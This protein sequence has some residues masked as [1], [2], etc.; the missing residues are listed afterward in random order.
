MNDLSEIAKN[1]KVYQNVSI[2][3]LDATT[4]K[5]VQE[6]CGHNSATNSM[7]LG[8]G[9]YLIGNG[10]FDQAS[11]TLSRYLPRY[12]SL[13]TMGLD[14]QN[15]D[16]NNL[17]IG[18]TDA[19]TYMAEVPGFAADHSSDNIED[20]NNRPWFGLGYPY[21]NFDVNDAYA[22]GDIVYRR[23]NKYVC[24]TAT[25][26]SGWNDSA[27]ELDLDGSRNSPWHELV[28]PT[29]PRVPISFREVIPSKD[30]ETKRTI[31]VVFSAM[32]SVGALAQFRGNNDYIYISE[33]GLWNSPT[34]V[35]GAYNGLI[36]G[37]RIVPPDKTNWD[38]SIPE[39][40][41]ILKSNILRVG[42]NQVVQVVWK[43][44]LGALDELQSIGGIVEWN[45]SPDTSVMST[46]TWE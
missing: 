35:G 20:N 39:N 15:Y 31:D 24:I 5:V 37:Y 43:I 10:V 6:H 45:V 12:M 9:Y 46:L 36:A 13:G 42:K 23:G 29:F 16:S 2:R 32:I 7:L 44:Q 21:D 18:I 11:S 41:E 1:L 19:I 40:V 3:V 34:W 17:P 14:N 26:P 30:A 4:G 28:S 25:G 33:A 27:W 22:I 38:M 8:I